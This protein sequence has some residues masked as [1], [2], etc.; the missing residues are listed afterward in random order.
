[1]RTVKREYELLKCER[2]G[3]E[4]KPYKPYAQVKLCAKCK[5]AYWDRA[6]KEKGDV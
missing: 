2:C 4:W 6:R 5:S 3:Y 1:M